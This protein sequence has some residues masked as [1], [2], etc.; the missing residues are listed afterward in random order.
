MSKSMVGIT[1]GTG[2]NQSFVFKLNELRTDILAIIQNNYITQNLSD[3]SDALDVELVN[4]QIQTLS[5]IDNSLSYISY[6]ILE[7]ISSIDVS[8][9][10]LDDLKTTLN[11]YS[12]NVNELPYARVA[13]IQT[14][15]EEMDFDS[16]YTDLRDLSYVLNQTN[17][18]VHAYTS[19]IRTRAA[20]IEEPSVS[21]VSVYTDL[22]DISQALNQSKQTI[23]TYTSSI[24]AT[25]STLDNNNTNTLATSIYNDLGDMSQALNQTKE[26]IETYTSS[27]EDALKDIQ[28]NLTTS[29]YN[30]LGDIWQTLN[31]TKETIET[32]TS[33]IEDALKEIQN[34]YTASIYNNL[35]D[36]WQT[37]NQT[38]ETINTYTS[39][40]REARNDISDALT[41]VTTNVV[42]YT[43]YISNI[44]DRTYDLSLNLQIVDVSINIAKNVVSDI[45]NTSFDDT[46]DASL[47]YIYNLLNYI[48]FTSLY[49]ELS[50]VHDDHIIIQN[51]IQNIDTCMNTISIP[52]LDVSSIDLCFQAMY[53]TLSSE[54]LSISGSVFSIVSNIQS[55]DVSSIDL[56][57][58][59]MYDTLSSEILSISGSVF[60]IASNIQSIDVSSIDLCFQAMYDTISQEILSISESVFSIDSATINEEIQQ[61]LIDVSS[62]DLCFQT[63]YVTISGDMESISGTITQI[64]VS[65]IEIT[66]SIRASVTEIR[67]DVSF[68]D[69]CFQIMYES[70]SGYMESISGSLDNLYR[71]TNGV[72]DKAVEIRN[73]IS[74]SLSQF[75]AIPYSNTFLTIDTF[76]Q[77][78]D[79]SLNLYINELSGNLV[80]IQSIVTDARDALD[81]VADNLKSIDYDDIFEDLALITQRESRIVNSIL[82]IDMNSR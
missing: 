59:S 68:I 8:V 63:M 49:T 44:T 58:Q 5:N 67:S 30:D 47:T 27:I 42:G 80:S 13:E 82:I 15:L 54:I 21:F 70:I 19:S 9:N 75:N 64:D 81:D 57:F 35:G 72:S 71:S 40:M 48:S 36:I 41:A 65:L 76:I 23:E 66:Q 52:Y 62:I 29:I 28:N 2:S 3:I 38:K 60:S 73:D 1:G 18:L 4:E 24:R 34:S 6:D 61:R 53:D 7:S 46:T 55:I 10:F 17:D 69:V 37:L 45:R 77:N 51:T 26:T 74:S 43:D 20:A 14:I 56:C 50:F 33:S 31:Q 78:T 12:N 79:A 25:L 39:S 32:Y 11:D 22:D 16:P